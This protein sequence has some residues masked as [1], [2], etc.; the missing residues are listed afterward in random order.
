MGL[1]KLIVLALAFAAVW[2]FF[3]WLNRRERNLLRQRS[4]R[5]PV[6]EAEDL[7]KCGV[8]G[9]FVA[10]GSAGCARADCP[11]PR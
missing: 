9:A 11:R 4:A 10:A 2:S 7:T 8:C 5:R 6:L 3:R 1:P